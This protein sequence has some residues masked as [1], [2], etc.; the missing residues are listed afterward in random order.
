MMLNIFN[1]LKE[2][3]TSALAQIGRMPVPGGREELPT[4]IFCTELFDCIKY[5]GGLVSNLLF[6]LVLISAVILFLIGALAYV[7]YGAK[8]DED[9]IKKAKNYLI[10]S[11]VAAVIASLAWVA[12][13]AIVSTLI[14]IKP[15]F[16]QGDIFTLTAK[17]ANCGSNPEEVFRNCVA[18]PTV[19]ILNYIYWAALIL[20][21]VMIIWSGINYITSRGKP[22]VIK[23]S[24]ATLIWAGVG[25]VVAILSWFI[26]NLI[27]GIFR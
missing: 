23:K 11:V 18:T 9:K 3:F 6:V 13:N 19:K 26:I 16:A 21:L 27:L 7:L 17:T 25:V 12:I 10:Y 5:F 24:S 8:G 2:N 14:F 20:A 4:T 15:V 22:E 1:V